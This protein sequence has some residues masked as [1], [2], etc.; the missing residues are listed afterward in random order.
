MEK[1]E[2]ATSTP[3][4]RKRGKPFNY[5]HKLIK[6]CAFLIMAICYYHHTFWMLPMYYEGDPHKEWKMKIEMALVYLSL[7]ILISTFIIVGIVEPGYTFK[8][9]E[10]IITDKA[11]ERLKMLS[12]EANRIKG[13]K[14]LDTYVK[15]HNKRIDVPMAEFK[16]NY[17]YSLFCKKCNIY[18]YPRTHHCSVCNTCVFLMDH[19]CV[20]LDNC[21][22]VNNMRYFLA[23][24]CVAPLSTLYYNIYA[25]PHYFEIMWENGSVM[26]I[27]ALFT[28]TGSDL[29]EMTAY[30]LGLAVTIVLGFYFVK[31]IHGM[32]K[33]TSSLERLRDE[34]DN[35]YHIEFNK[36]WD[37]VFGRTLF[38]MSFVL[39][40]WMTSQ[41]HIDIIMKDYYRFDKVEVTS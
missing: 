24:L 10:K 8:Q 6:L 19:H 2:K 39:A 25:F 21:V 16:D 30:H 14:E 4:G 36:A 12:K 13:E 18:R 17:N 7:T 9:E 26:S 37:S 40:P 27:E 29:F 28:T 1:E 15:D 33:G 20:W 31:I 22:G 34:T 23:F 3:Y 11:F 35:T 5:L 32:S 41:K 38:P